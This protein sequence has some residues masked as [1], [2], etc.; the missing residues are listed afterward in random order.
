MA[1]TL[2][3]RATRRIE[4]F[5]SVDRLGLGRKDCAS[6]LGIGSPDRVV[7][8]GPAFDEHL[9]FCQLYSP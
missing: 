2:N 4:F 9:I 3:E 5:R 1:D 6:A 7:T 8:L